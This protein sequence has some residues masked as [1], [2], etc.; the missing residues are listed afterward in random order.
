[1]SKDKFALVKRHARMREK[2]K[3]ELK[4]REY[5]RIQDLEYAA[6]CRSSPV[7]WDWFSRKYDPVY[8]RI[9]DA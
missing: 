1:M 8:K 2:L 9:V 6:Q 3:A 4:R 7:I 5:R